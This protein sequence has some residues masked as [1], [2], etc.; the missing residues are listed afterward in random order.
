MEV[1]SK[2]LQTSTNGNQG[3]LSLIIGLLNQFSAIA[4]LRMMKNSGKVEPRQ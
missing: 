4:K 1:F 2:L 3:N